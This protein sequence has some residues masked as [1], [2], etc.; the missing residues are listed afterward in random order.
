[1]SASIPGAVPFLPEAPRIDGRLDPCLQGLPAFTFNRAIKTAEGNPTVE[2]SYRLA[3]GAD[4]LYLYLEWPAEQ[5]V[6]R[7][8]GYQNGDGFIL[9]LAMPRPEN[10]P[11]EEFYVL[12]FSAQDDPANNWAKQIVWY[13]NVDTILSML[14]PAVQLAWDVQDGRAAFELLLPWKD[15]YPYHPWFYDAIGF[16][17]VFV[18]AVGKKEA[19]YYFAL[20]DDNLGAEGAPRI[21]LPLNFAAPRLERGGQA[22]L[23]LDR[24]CQAGE[25]V[26]AR[27]ALLA[28]GSGEASV[29]VAIGPGEGGVL[30]SERVSL[31]HSV[32]LV[33]HEHDLNTATLPPGG[34]RIQWRDRGHGQGGEIGLTVLPSLELGQFAERLLGV[35]ER[36]SAS[37]CSTLRFQLE[38]IGRR[39]ER[40]KPYETCGEVNF[41]LARWL[42]DVVAAA[43]GQDRLAAK[44][45]VFRRAFRSKIDGTLQPYSV[46]VPADYDPTKRHPLLVMLHGS[47]MTEQGT[48]ES[49]QAMVPQGWLAI[50]PYGRG[51]SHYYCP[52]EAQQDIQEALADAARSYA[53][54]LSRVVL[55]GFSMGGY[56][57]YRTYYET[58]DRYRALAVFAGPVRLNPDW[59]V[60][61]APDFGQDEVVQT[62]TTVPLF[63]W[64]GRQDH[65]VPIDGTL[66]LVEKLQALGAPVELYV[67]EN[68]GHA[69]PAEEAS[70]AY[71]RW[72]EGVV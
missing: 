6:Y 60:T 64:H 56:G 57:A 61:S 40:V 33:I 31:P 12:G 53:I 16:N 39:L 37:S 68:V 55:A 41:S 44:T 3:Y 17:L 47:G 70:R 46:Y 72:L 20:Q 26:R 7:D 18:E 63:I 25:T 29:Q 24:H 13:Y 45:G 14:S 10:A 27:L 19:N 65:N 50:A 51:M 15:V 1:M 23:Y 35:E 38:E 11:T 28:A 66:A 52:P 43:A 32:G 2:A 62:L 30:F 34:Y 59:G 4:F 5:I 42:E 58:P 54:D 8:R 22:A 69:K 71:R 48:L 36:I 21:Y 49:I 9:V 67:E